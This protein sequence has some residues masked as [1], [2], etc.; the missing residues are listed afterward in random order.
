M[1]AGSQ[2]KRVACNYYGQNYASSM[3]T[4]GTKLIWIHLNWYKKHLF[5]NKEAKQLSITASKK[6]R[7]T[8]DSDKIVSKLSQKEI[9]AEITRYFIIDELPFRYVDGRGFQIFVKKAYPYFVFPLRVIV[10]RDIYQLHLDNRKKLKNELK[11]HIMS[12]IIDC[13]TS[14]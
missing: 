5:S 7:E 6:K 2:P 11:M 3:K 12:L 10:A 4:C 8:R 13:W 14:I 9:R 1:L